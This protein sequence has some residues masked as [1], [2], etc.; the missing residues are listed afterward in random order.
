MKLLLWAEHR[1]GALTADSLAA[2]TAAAGLGTVDLLVTGED[3]ARA[4]E[5][6]R[7]VQGVARVLQGG[8]ADGAPATAASVAQAIAAA[9]SGYDALAAPASAQARRIVPRV[10]ALLDVMAVSG[11]VAIPAPDTFVRPVYAG[12]ALMTVRSSDA[13]RVFT[14]RGT[15]FAKAPR[16]A[17]AAPVE[18]FALPAPG[19]AEAL[20]ERS[21]P[22]SDRP[23]LEGAAIVVSGGRGLRDAAGFAAQ[24]L[25]LADRLG[26]AVGASRAAVDAGFVSNEHQV[27]QTG[28]LVA[29]DL[30]IAL[31]ISGAIQHLAGMKDSKTIVAINS[32]PDAPIFEVAD[33]GLEADLFEAVPELV[34]SL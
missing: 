32:D 12:N 15:A 26:A 16:G 30:Y 21:R 22:T 19:G 1:D 17:A 9:M 3:A 24:V 20:V 25:P 33:Y 29:P 7:T 6:A 14:V 10:A 34:R 2:V 18:P 23:A 28:K 31:G 11:V 8:T 27:G 4:A 13:K 5:D